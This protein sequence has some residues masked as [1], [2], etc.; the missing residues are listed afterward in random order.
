VQKVWQQ[1]THVSRV[2]HYLSTS[3][4]TRDAVSRSVLP[5]VSRCALRS[6]AAA[7]RANKLEP[8]GSGQQQSLEQRR[9]RGRRPGQTW[10]DDDGPSLLAAR[11][12][13][14]GSTDGCHAPTPP[15]TYRRLEN[16]PSQRSEIFLGGQRDSR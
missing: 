1:S 6:E 5:R 14:E 16:V 13:R 11:P 3:H 7:P 10:R 12:R 9:R 8:V 15:S 2:L 4:V